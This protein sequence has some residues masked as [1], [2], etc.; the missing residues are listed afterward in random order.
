MMSSHKRAEQAILGSMLIGDPS[1]EIR[2]EAVDLRRL[3]RPLFNAMRRIIARGERPN[4][5]NI[6][7][8]LKTVRSNSLEKL[9]GFPYLAELAII[10]EDEANVEG[11]GHGWNVCEAMI[12]KDASDQRIAESVTPEMPLDGHV[13]ATE[14]PPDEDGE[15]NGS[16]EPEWDAP[17]PAEH[18][19]EEV[20]QRRPPGQIRVGG[21]I[22]AKLK[23]APVPDGSVFPCGWT[24]DRVGR[25]CKIDESEDGEGA[26]RP[27]CTRP[28]LISSLDFD[29]HERVYFLTITWP[30]KRDKRWDECNVRRDVVASSNKIP[31]LAAHGAPATSTNAKRLVWWFEVFEE[32]NAKIIPERRVSQTIGWHT[33]NHDLQGFLL[34]EEWIG[35][36]SRAIYNVSKEG[37]E[38]MSGA[39]H[40]RGDEE[41]ERSTI[42]SAMNFPMIAAVVGASLSAPLLR[43]LGCPG[44][45]LSLSGQTSTGKTSAMRVGAAIWGCPDERE[46]DST[47]QTWDASKKWILRTASHLDGIPLLLD[48]TQRADGPRTVQSILYGVPSGRGRGL[49]SRTESG[50]RR[51]ASSRTVLISSGEIP[52][53]ESSQAGGTRARV[54]ELWGQPWG[55]F[56]TDTGRL[57]RSIQWQLDENYGHTAKR[58]VAF[59]LRNEKSWRRWRDQYRERAIKIADKFASKNTMYAAV[60]GRLA[61]YIAAIE[62]ALLL[63]MK[64][65]IITGPPDTVVKV[66]RHIVKNAVREA[67]DRDMP[68]EALQYVM[69]VAASRQS[70]FWVKGATYGDRSKQPTRG[71]LGRWDRGEGLIMWIN[72]A[73]RHVLK[74]GDF[75]AEGVLRAWNERGWIKPG[76]GGK[77]TQPQLVG[78]KTV[79]VI[80]IKS[81]KVLKVC[82]F[83]PFDEDPEQEDLHLEGGNLHP[84]Y[85]EV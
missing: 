54:L 75:A 14:E 80:Q 17:H 68:T 4:E 70:E 65:G 43:V 21:K 7:D 30:R 27:M 9:G 42:H 59:V 16:G 2:V 20:P 61:E 46:S 66:V 78:E 37:V 31:Q 3:H 39:L 18:G 44:Y 35:E 71:W 57:I 49:A 33:E 58:W 15:D 22:K 23:N 11:G 79:R 56:S 55:K 13:P 34:G 64:E 1:R 84:D 45:V 32:A 82:G 83:D 60:T 38:Q 63:A 26:L 67:E 53:L 73:I 28:L 74:E 24:V 6:P 8:E 62:V 52:I 10:A 85:T 77:L 5:T 51:I 41:L 48:D 29:V 40:A 76:S 36:E 25:L 81:D 69:D 47:L 72:Q 12:R 50:T 19:D